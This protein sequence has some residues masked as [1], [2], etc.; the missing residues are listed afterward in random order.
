MF[1]KSILLA[2]LIIYLISTACFGV[3]GLRYNW[4]CT[5]A[6]EGGNLWNDPNNWDEAEYPDFNDLA[7]IGADSSIDC[8][9]PAGTWEVEGIKVEDGGKLILLPGVD[10]TVNNRD[11][12]NLKIA[13][14]GTGTL[15]VRSGAY[16]YKDGN[17]VLGKKSGNEAHFDIYGG[18]A[19]ASGNINM[20]V[21]DA[22]GY[23]NIYDGGEIT[24]SGLSLENGQITI[25]EGKMLLTG[26]DYTSQLDTL[27]ENGDI[28]PVD[29]RSSIANS[30]IGGVTTLEIIPPDPNK[31]WGSQPI[32]NVYYQPTDLSFN[33]ADVGAD[34]HIV[35]Y[36]TGFEDV[37]NADYTASATSTWQSDANG[38]YYKKET[39]ESV[40]VNIPSAVLPVM[41]DEDYHWR[42]DEVNNTD[43]IVYKGDTYT[44]DIPFI[45]IDDFEDYAD[46]TELS[47]KWYSPYDTV[48]IEESLSEYII[49]SKSL[50][51]VYYEDLEADFVRKM[52][53]VSGYDEDIDLTDL[54]QGGANNMQ[55]RFKGA[56]GTYEQQ[57]SL[58]LSDGSN[59][60]TIDY[61]GGET[62]AC[63]AWEPFRIW[64]IDL[65]GDMNSVD[66]QNVQE[67][68]LRLPGTGTYTA[69]P[70]NLYIDNIR[71]YPSRC[72][73]GVV[74]T[75][76]FDGDCVVDLDDVGI[77]KE[78]WLDKAEDVTPVN[79][80][81]PEL[82]YDWDH[83]EDTN[84]INQGSL[85]SSYD[86]DAQTVQKY[87]GELEPLDDMIDAN[88]Y[89]G[90]CFYSDFYRWESV[91]QTDHTCYL[92]P[93]I[94]QVLADV[95]EVTVSFWAKG[96]DLP[97]HTLAF[98]FD[99][100]ELTNRT[101]ILSGNVT[102]TA[103]IAFT[104]QT[105]GEDTLVFDT[106]DT[107][108]YEGVWNHYA[109]VK[110][111]EKG[112]QRIYVNGIVVAEDQ[113]YTDFSGVEN[114]VIGGNDRDNQI[115]SGRID[116]FKLF[117]KALTPG[118]V[119][120][121]AGLSGTVS[122]P[123]IS[124]ADV[125]DDGIIDLKDLSGIAENWGM[126]VLWP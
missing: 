122:Q 72:I 81:T 51:L 126:E 49:D 84:S 16:I 50:K 125:E 44:F 1:R 82:H 37:N 94:S 40:T 108:Q 76:S 97:T 117:T 124:P 90:D 91:A 20:G 41:D 118:E 10:L 2:F 93:G 58:I 103:D 47:N 65:T 24:A 77:M 123:L 56:S 64:N 89:S 32:G 21:S 25:G 23:L 95:N 53:D 33:E 114:F 85:G 9:I 74:P 54:T 8:N 98:Y 17:F 100:R 92:V 110:D 57:L 66:L 99:G 87:N 69:E 75:E 22:T 55:I 7:I 121:E 19:E 80:G 116:E 36:G 109:F 35:Y 34:E 61:T 30:V 46:S 11:L 88:G 4:Q 29:S 59:T 42:V 15:E 28:V 119:A 27:L 107:S 102:G 73:E 105:D 86:Y 14:S 115:Y 18:V 60:K 120:Y 67:I 71:L 6:N 111:A 96:E 12:L 113:E 63:E 39:G 13:F 68:K 101:T 52:Y 79:P 31:V 43:S 26:G 5:D 83:L 62:L 70:N 38:I 48:E 3:T 45:K 112:I 106:N 104:S 78:N